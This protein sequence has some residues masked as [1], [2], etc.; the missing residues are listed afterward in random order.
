MTITKL[1]QGKD[2]S[3]SSREIAELM[4][5][6][7]RNV[8]RDIEKMLSALGRGVLNFEHTYVNQQNGQKYRE[9][10]LPKNLTLTLIAGYRADLRLRIIERW[11]ELEQQ[12]GTHRIPTTLPEALRLAA[13]QA[14]RMAVLEPKAAALDAI[15]EA[16][17]DLGVRDAGRELGIGQNRLAQLMM[18][19]RWAC[20][21]GNKGRLKPAHYGLS[22]GYVRMVA[23]FYTDLRTGEDRMA[24]V[25]VLTRKG[26]ARMAEKISAEGA[27]A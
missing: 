2:L 5:K 23:R 22:T 15:S 1:E 17:G 27:L 14:E 19:M 12:Q 11:D 18:E 8:T 13:E 26:L 3:L 10:R 6:S 25:L 20:R 16:P 21:E 4:G 9:Y 24:D 7:H